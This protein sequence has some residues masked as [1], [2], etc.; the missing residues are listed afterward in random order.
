MLTAIREFNDKGEDQIL[1]VGML[2]ENLSLDKLPPTE[3]F[4]TLGRIY[5]ELLP[6]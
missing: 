6:T 1:R 3:V 2:P 5:G 4:Q